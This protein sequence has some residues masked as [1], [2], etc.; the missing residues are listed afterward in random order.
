MR[1]FQ[2]SKVYAAQNV[3]HW[4]FDTAAET[5]NP[6]VTVNNVTV[7]LPPEAKFACTD[8]IQSYVDRVVEMVDS[9][10]PAPT[11]RARKGATKAHYQAGTI[12]IP[13]HRE[14][15]WALREMVVLHELA[16]HLAHD[17]HGPNFASKFLMLLGVVMGPEA[18]LVGRMVFIDNGVLLKSERSP[19]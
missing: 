11:V 6:M 19:A 7:T 5:G 1:D 3:M 2:K 14:G 10:R 8:S 13:L 15:R 9:D 12:A 17:G 18:E 4:L 16:H